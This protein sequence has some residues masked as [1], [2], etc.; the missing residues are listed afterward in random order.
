METGG[1]SLVTEDAVP[2]TSGYDSAV[3]ENFYT[4]DYVDTF[5]FVPDGTAGLHEPAVTLVA[6]PQP[7]E[8]AKERANQQQRPRQKRKSTSSLD[9]AALVQEQKLMREDLQAARAKELALRERHMAAQ[10]KLIDALAKYFDP[11]QK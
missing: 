1:S 3:A 4:D 2:S 5:D 8:P 11:A 10:E 7:V 9:F 6:S